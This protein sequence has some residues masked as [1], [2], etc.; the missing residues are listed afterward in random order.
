MELIELQCNS[1]LKLHV[2]MSTSKSFINTL[3]QPI[4]RHK[5]IANEDHVNV[6]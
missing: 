1:V 4:P 5:R 3:D 2:K 6:R